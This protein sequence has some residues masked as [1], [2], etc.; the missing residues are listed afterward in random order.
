MNF[1]MSDK[2]IAVLNLPEEENR[3]QKLKCYTLI[4][5]SQQLSAI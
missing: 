2:I 5:L 4:Y 3:S 1:R